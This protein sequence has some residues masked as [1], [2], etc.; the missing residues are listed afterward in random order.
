MAAPSHPEE[1]GLALSGGGFRATLFHIGSLW[2]LNEMGW[3]PKINRYSSVSGGTITAAQLGLQWSR[4]EFDASGVAGNFPTLIAAPLQRFCA[5][6]MD[7]E[8]GFEGLFSFSETIGE[9]VASK[10]SE[11]L[12]GKATLQD[13]PDGDGQPEFII[14]ATSLQTGS[15]FRFSKRYLADYKV[16]LLRNPK[17][18]LATAVAASSAFP[19]ALSPVTLVTEPGEWEKVDGAYLH[20]DAHVALRTKVF[21]ADGGVYDNMGLETIWDRT[22]TVLVSD[23]GAPLTTVLGPSKS[24]LE[25]TARV[26]DIVTDQTRALR[27]R[28]LIDDFENRQRLGSYWGIRTQIGGYGLAD[29]CAKDTDLSRSLAAMRTRLDAFSDEEQGRL[30]NWGYAL[31]DAAMRKHL[32]V[33]TGPAAWPVPAYPL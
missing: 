24:W 13:L 12:F 23:A 29:A 25:Q 15:S 9:K 3:L 1:T 18:P 11:G 17:V 10:Y 33:K 7:V 30:I 4:L 5:K 27:K 21:L 16:G 31:T 32:A 8:A 20:D 22:G 6:G 26:L 2:R 19:P 14:Y 28:R